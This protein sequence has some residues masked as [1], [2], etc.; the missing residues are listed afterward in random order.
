M[1]THCGGLRVTARRAQVQQ[2][3]FSDLE[4]ARM[5]T[6]FTP[7]YV[8]TQMPGGHLTKRFGAKAVLAVNNT[9]VA[10][11]LLALPAAGRAGAWAVCAALVAL[12]AVQGPYV[13]AAAVM[14]NTWMPAADS[15]AAA[16]RPLAQMVIRFG[17]QCAKLLAA[18]LTP[19][20][21]GRFGWMAVPRVYGVFVVAC[22][23][24]FVVLTPSRPR[25]LVAPAPDKQP[26]AGTRR[27]DDV[28]ILQMVMSAPSQV[29]ECSVARPTGVPSRSCTGASRHACGATSATTRWSF[30]YSALG[31]RPT[32]TRSSACRWRGSGSTCAGL[33]RPGWSANLVLTI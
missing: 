4:T 33:T 28:S 9:V 26:A 21:A 7:G 32:T 16:E 8:L 5:L 2:N 6:A 1:S 13:S 24:L 22:S 18:A 15:P 11:V 27:Q 17:Q 25:P 20:M 12:G 31:R 10:L 19:W 23:A 29:G 14:Q 30:T 3:G